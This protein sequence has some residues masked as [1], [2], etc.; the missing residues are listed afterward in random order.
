MNHDFFQSKKATKILALLLSIFIILLVFNAGLRIGERR[1]SFAYRDADRYFQVFDGGL[2]SGMRPPAFPNVH[3]AAG[4]I[5][6]VRLPGIV[7]KDRDGSEKTVLVTDKTAIRK[8]RDE[9]APSA[10]SLGD[11]VVVF[12]DPNEDSQIEARLIRLIPEIQK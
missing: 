11:M 12:G 5:V 10:L 7:V 1:A 8:L 3:G 6:S 9:V 4:E 2:R